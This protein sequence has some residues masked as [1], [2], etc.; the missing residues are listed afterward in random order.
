MPR[1]PPVRK[2]RRRANGEGSTWWDPKRRRYMGQ[3][4]VYDQVGNMKRRTVS[5]PTQDE[6]ATKLDQLKRSASSSVDNPTNLTVSRFLTYWLD[7]VLPIENKAPSTERGYR[8]V[9]RLYIDPHIG[10]IE[11]A[12][13]TPADVTRMMAALQRQGMGPVT[14]A[15]SRKVLAR[16]LKVAVRDGLVMRNPATLVDG[17]QVPRG[18]QQ[19]LTVDQ[20]AQLLK[21]ADSAGYGTLVTVMLGLGLRRGEVLGLRW[22]DID[23]DADRPTL[24]V[25]G[26]IGDDIHGKQTWRPR[27][28]TASSRRNLH[29]PQAVADSLRAHHRLQAR[30]QLSCPEPWGRDWP[31]RDFVFTTAVGTPLDA[32]RVT[33]T[34]IAIAAAAGLGHWTPHDLRHSAASLLI[35]QGVT[36][37]EVSEALGHSSIR[38]TAD[39]YGHLYEPARVAVADA[40][41]A[42]IF[43]K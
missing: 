1:K 36:L 16:A 30:D 2:Q 9:C 17:V 32:D 26:V 20:A 21:A 5:A 24:T 37:K 43:A 42:A 27:P 12:R 31:H 18:E 10:R 6:L 39:I 19:V 14:V 23:L 40:M 8:D 41:Q 4:T 22:R 29:L 3:I 7:D 15:K 11:L 33:K 34:V 35:A 28:K 25:V 13:L 38:V